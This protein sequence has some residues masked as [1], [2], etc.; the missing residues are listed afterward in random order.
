M[1]LTFSATESPATLTSI[2]SGTVVAR[3]D[4]REDDHGFFLDYLWTDPAF[5][6]RGYARQM[7]DHFA[8]YVGE[9]GKRISPICGVARA[10]MQGD[11]RY[12]EVLTVGLRRR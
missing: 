10:M 9:R 1:E 11:A 8:A 12:T 3:I 2:E 4:Y 5:R 7:V 6:G